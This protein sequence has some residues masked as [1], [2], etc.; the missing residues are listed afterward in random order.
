MT[1]KRKKTAT[2]VKMKRVSVETTE[3]V[4]VGPTHPAWT[5]PSNADNGLPIYSRSFSKGAIAKLV[6]PPGTPESY[7]ISMERSLYAAG[8]VSVKVMPTQEELRITVEGET[9]DVDSD[10][11]ARTLRQVALERCDWV[12]NA[13]DSDALKALVGE[14]MDY[15]ES[16]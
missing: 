7:V 1:R 6:P 2:A 3:L 14:A 12:T 11:D 15:A 8:A 10:D 16:Q 13:H 4:E 5:D 9:F